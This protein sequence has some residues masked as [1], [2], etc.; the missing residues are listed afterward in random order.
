MAGDVVGR[1][2]LL[3][4]LATIKRLGFWLTEHDVLANDA[5]VCAIS[6][7]GARRPGVD[8]QTRVVSIFHYRDG[9]QVER[10]IFPEDAA[11]WDRIFEPDAQGN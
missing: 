7:M 11:I 4:W 9:R 10:W 6:H 8:I 5:H 1:D 3:V 2:T